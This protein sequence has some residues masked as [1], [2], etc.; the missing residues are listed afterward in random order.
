M[1]S[2]PASRIRI[3]NKDFESSCEAN[4]SGLEAVRSEALRAA[5]QIGTDEVCAG[6]PFFGAEI[7]IENEHEPVERLIIA[8]GTSPLR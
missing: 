8:I 6:K 3:T 1:T 7:A 2:M 5:L 4:A